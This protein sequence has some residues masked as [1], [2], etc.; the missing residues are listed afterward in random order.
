MRHARAFTYA[1]TND[2]SVIVFHAVMVVSVLALFSFTVR[3]ADATIKMVAN[4]TCEAENRIQC[5]LRHSP[6]FLAAVLLVESR[7]ATDST[8]TVAK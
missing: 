5:G 2:Q 6:A 8:S 3:Y 4:A 7:S 1:P